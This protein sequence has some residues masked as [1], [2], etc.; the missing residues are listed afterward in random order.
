MPLD[1]RY[2]QKGHAHM[3][4]IGSALAGL[5]DG[6][7][8]SHRLSNSVSFADVA[9]HNGLPVTPEGITSMRPTGASNPSWGV[10]L[11][12]AGISVE[13]ILP[14]NPVCGHADSGQL[15]TSLPGRR[16][17]SWLTSVKTIISRQ[18]LRTN[19][20]STET[21]RANQSNDLPSHF[22][23]AFWDIWCQCID[24]AK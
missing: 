23:C 7:N 4:K 11:S 16:Y 17:A 14:P 6:G 5:A 20:F 24:Q 2:P 12:I 9:K 19:H 3:D 18:P 15:R 10:W 21:H 13:S 8:F 1:A 22:A